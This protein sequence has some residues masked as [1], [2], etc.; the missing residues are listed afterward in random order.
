MGT[1]L[2]LT[3]SHAYPLFATSSTYAKVIIEGNPAAEVLMAEIGSQDSR[4]IGEHHKN[5]IKYVV[6]Y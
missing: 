6:I 4:V 1:S 3:A 5:S 2:R